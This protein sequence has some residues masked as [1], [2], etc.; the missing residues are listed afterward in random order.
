LRDI[1]KLRVTGK[2]KPG[3]QVR[4]SKNKRTFEKGYLP[5]WTE[6]IF[7]IKKPLKKFTQPLAEIEDLR[8][9]RIVGTFY[10]EEIQKIKT[11]AETAYRIEKVIKSRKKGRITEYFVKWLG[12]PEEFNS[13]VPA[14]EF[15]K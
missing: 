13:W 3:D 4:I 7:K 9:N 10:P 1:L 6:E 2:L 14:S 8:K 5:N 12:Y 15:V 11:T